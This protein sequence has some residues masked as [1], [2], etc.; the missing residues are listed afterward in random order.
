M[1]QSLPQSDGF[2]ILFNSPELSEVQRSGFHLF[3]KKG[4]AEELS[5]ISCIQ[6]KHAHFL[7][8][9]VLD[10]QDFRLITP[11]N[12]Y[13]DCILKMKSYTCKLYV[14]AKI[15]FKDKVSGE[16][17]YQTQPEW[18]LLA[19]LP[20]MTKRGHFVINGSPRVIV[21][22][23]GR[24]PGVYFKKVLKVK[25]DVNNKARFYGDII[26]R[27]G[28]WVRLQ[29]NKKGEVDLKL[30]KSKKVRAEMVQKCLEL[31]EK[32][33]ACENDVLRMQ[34]KRI[35]ARL[36]KGITQLNPV[37]LSSSSVSTNGVQQPFLHLQKKFSIS[38]L[39]ALPKQSLG[40]TRKGFVLPDS[41]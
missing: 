15:V 35:P 5:K 28:V 21:H 40:K 14:Q 18:V 2:R 25:K 6:L 13:R 30:K 10:A 17:V 37:K 26:P 1:V 19:D 12:N 7:I 9:I 38:T 33:A 3:L 4:I 24:A 27:K 20:L 11:E 34:S 41:W 32:E 16:L 31:L 22:Q 29:I 39:H 8:D 23:V 36:T